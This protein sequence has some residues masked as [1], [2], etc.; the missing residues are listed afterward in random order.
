MSYLLWSNRYL[1]SQRKDLESF[2]VESIKSVIDIIY[3]AIKKGNNIFVCGNGGSSS[4]AS[5]FTNDL[6]KSSGDAINKKVKVFCLSENSSLVT[7]IS[8]DLNYKYI[9]SKQLNNL[10]NK[11]DVLLLISV[12]GNSENLVEACKS[13]KMNGL[14]IVSLT[15]S[16]GG[17]ISEFSDVCIKIN[18]SHYGRVEDCQMTILHMICYYL[19]EEVDLK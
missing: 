1:E 2:D 11:D 19:I 17:K 14:K 5:H 4:N 9:F 6:M 3:S 8:N 18:D 15:N 12:S 16:L 10:G 7:A 13:A